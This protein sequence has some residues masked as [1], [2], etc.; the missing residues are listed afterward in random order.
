MDLFRAFGASI[1]LWFLPG[2]LPRAVTFRAFGAAM[3]L[4]LIRHAELTFTGGATHLL[5][6]E[7]NGNTR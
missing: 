7:L 1:G 4:S 3:N 5:I 6:H 2:A